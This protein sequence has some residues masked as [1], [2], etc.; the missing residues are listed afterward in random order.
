VSSLKKKLFL[1]KAE[2]DYLTSNRKFDNDYSYT[3]KSRLVKKLHQFINQELPLL[4]EKGYLTEFCKL[5]DNCKVQQEIGSSL[6]KI[7]PQTGGLSLKDSNDYKSND[8]KKMG[9]KGFEPLTP[10]MSRRY[11]N[12]ARP[13]ALT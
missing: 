2:R 9:R 7:P 12:Q 13:P 11:L 3:I 8:K 4:I 5:T 10:A 6:V 1:S